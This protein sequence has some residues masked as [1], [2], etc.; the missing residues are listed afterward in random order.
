MGASRI[1]WSISASSACSSSD[2]PCRIRICGGGLLRAATAGYR[3]TGRFRNVT[4][5]TLR[6]CRR[7]LAS[8]REVDRLLASPADTPDIP[9]HL[10]AGTGQPNRVAARLGANEFEHLV[11]NEGDGTVPL[12]SAWLTEPSGWPSRRR[13]GSF[14]QG[15]ATGPITQSLAIPW[16]RLATRASEGGK[17]AGVKGWSDSVSSRHIRPGGGRF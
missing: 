1:W 11:T 4:P 12:A 9:W 2:C 17:P 14:T 6:K 5:C 3:S 10:I 8:A 13:A 15:T 7:L 16:P